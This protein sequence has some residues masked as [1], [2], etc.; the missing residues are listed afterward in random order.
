MGRKHVEPKDTRHNHL[1]EEQ[2][3]EPSE[4][5]RVVHASGALLNCPDE[6]LHLRDMLIIRTNIEP[7]T[8][9]GKLITENFEL[10]IR[11]YHVNEETT[12]PIEPH[13]IDNGVP[14]IVL[15]S[16]QKKLRSAKTKIA[17]GGNQKR[18]LV[19][20]HDVR[21]ECHVPVAVKNVR[22]DGRQI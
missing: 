20:I 22:W 7:S 5:D 10:P 4:R 16:I 21:A 9:P 19:D 6:A 18:K 17:R 13:D 14:D 11:M 8:R 15:L 1:L 3:G 2:S 12:G